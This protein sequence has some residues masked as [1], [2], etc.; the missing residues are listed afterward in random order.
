MIYEHYNPSNQRKND[1]SARSLAKVLDKDYWQVL[2]ELKTLKRLN[3]ETRYYNLTNIKRYMKK[4]PFNKLKVRKQRISKFID[5]HPIGK[6]II[7]TTDHLTCV[8]DGVLYDSWDC[9]EL[10]VEEVWQ[11][12]E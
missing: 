3:R 5:T 2:K 7:T 4:Y 8:I 11:K 9:S 6:Y 12:G 10:K 1:C